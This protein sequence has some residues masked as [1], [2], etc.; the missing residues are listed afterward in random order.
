MSRFLG[1]SSRGG[2][3]SSSLSDGTLTMSNGMLEGVASINGIPPVQITTNTINIAGKQ[4]TISAANKTTIKG[5]LDLGNVNNTTDALKPVS[6]ATQTALNAK[7]PTV[8]ADN[9]GSIKSLLRPHLL[10]PM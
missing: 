9:A 4:A 10:W 1:A 5:T 3:Q 8:T 7:Q 6:T 2:I